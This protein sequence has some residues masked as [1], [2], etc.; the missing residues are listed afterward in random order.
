M[1]ACA[2]LSSQYEDI[3]P[4]GGIADNIHN[5]SNHDQDNQ[6]NRQSSKSSSKQFSVS[7]PSQPTYQQ[8][9]RNNSGSSS[10][11]DHWRDGGEATT[12]SA[13]YA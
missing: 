6:P 11:G 13:N 10:S 8:A 1:V 4:V 9:Y 3:Q 2:C 12:Q 7:R 5:D